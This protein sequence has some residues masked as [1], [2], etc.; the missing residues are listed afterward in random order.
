MTSPRTRAGRSAGTRTTSRCIITAATTS[1][2]GL[3][4]FILDDYDKLEEAAYEKA[5]ADAEARAQRLAKLSHVKLGPITAVRESSS[6][7]DKQ[8]GMMGQAQ[9]DEVPEK[10]LESSR[11]QEIPVK[12]ELMVRFDVTAAPG[13]NGRS[14]GQ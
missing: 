10:R 6:P 8:T 9:D 14:G 12:V 3:V 7:G 2:N 13:A 5:V 4:R 11:F 1:Q